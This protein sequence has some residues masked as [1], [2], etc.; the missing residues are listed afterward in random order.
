[1]HMEMGSSGSYVTLWGHLNR[2]GTMRNEVDVSA[3][4]FGQLTDYFT[5]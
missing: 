2:R 4:G 5:G 3:Q 1:M